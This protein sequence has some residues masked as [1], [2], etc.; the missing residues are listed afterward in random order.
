MEAPPRLRITR[1][2]GK[3]RVVADPGVSVAVDGGSV[4][5]NEDGSFEIHARGGALLEV[6]CPTGSDLTISTASGS[7]AVRGGVALW[8]A[9]ECGPRGRTAGDA[10]EVGVG[11]K[12]Q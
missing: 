3:V 4:E 2:S 11:P 9:Q 8:L 7:I 5:P 1:R 10:R 6:R 12:Q